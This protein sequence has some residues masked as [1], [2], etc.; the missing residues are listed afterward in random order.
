MDFTS[1]KKTLE[2]KGYKVCVFSTLSNAG[3]YLNLHIHNK[4]VALG[5]SM[6]LEKMGIYDKLITHN[7]VIWHHRI[8]ENSTSHEERLKA[9]SA[10][11]YLSSVNAIS[12]N[13]EIV[14][15]DAVCNRVSS[16]FYGHDKVYLIIG[17]NKVTPSLDEAIHRA[18]NVAS[19]KNAQ[20]LKRN[21]PCAIK[22]DK[23]YDCNSPDRICKGI[24][25]LLQAPLSSNIEILLIDEEVGY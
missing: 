11:I 16:I 9:R 19:P 1:L 14:N 12:Q 3:Q 15:I 20:R 2:K 25:I 13:G 5:G 17:K 8:P 10:Q 18:R 23:C 4:S 6:T 21:T 22:A 7:T 24:S